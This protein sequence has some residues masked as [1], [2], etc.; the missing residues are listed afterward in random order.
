MNDLE[1]NLLALGSDQKEFLLKFAK[2]RKGVFWA[3][4]YHA[5]AVD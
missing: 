5:T 2:D 4:R 3:E 1:L